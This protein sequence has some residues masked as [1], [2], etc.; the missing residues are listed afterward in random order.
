MPWWRGGGGVGAGVLRRRL[1]WVLQGWALSY[2]LVGILL[3]LMFMTGDWAVRAW[4]ERQEWL[5]RPV[6]GIVAMPLFLYAL[7]GSYLISVYVGL[8]PRR[9]RVAAKCPGC[10]YPLEGLTMTVSAGG[11]GVSRVEGVCPECGKEVGFEV[12]VEGSEGR[13]GG[14]RGSSSE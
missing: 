1:R 7:A 3:I 9:G 10:D 14:E 4:A 11:D 13:A 6:P 5:W 2:S 8:R 12:T